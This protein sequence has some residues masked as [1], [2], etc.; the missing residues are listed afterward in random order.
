[1]EGEGGGEV[2]GRWGEEEGRR[3]GGELG[4]DIPCIMEPFHGEGF[5]LLQHS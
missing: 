3:R 1:M 4:R 2:R 5:T